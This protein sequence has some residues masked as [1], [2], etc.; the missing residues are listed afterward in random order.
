VLNVRNFLLNWLCRSNFKSC[1]TGFPGKSGFFA[2]P[3]KDDRDRWKRQNA[4]GD[5]AS[6]S[7]RRIPL[8]GGGN[9][10]EESIFSRAPKRRVPSLQQ[11]DQAT[12]FWIYRPDRQLLGIGVG[13]HL[14]D[15]A[16]SECPTR[17]YGRNFC[18]LQEPMKFVGEI[19]SGPWRGPGRWVGLSQ[20]ASVIGNRGCEIRNRRLDVL[21]SIE[22]FAQAI[23][24]HHGW[25]ATSCN[26]YVKLVPTNINVLRVV[27]GRGCSA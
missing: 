20:S 7:S 27:C 11:L 12:V 14:D 8:I 9:L 2:C 13:K 10:S 4:F 19:L 1:S 24:E 18:G 16:S 21:P 6:T 3:L 22:G 17:M 26:H 25:A 15:S 23:L 5:S